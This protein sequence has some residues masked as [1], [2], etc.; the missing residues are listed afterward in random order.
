[1]PERKTYGSKPLNTWSQAAVAACDWFVNSQ[2]LQK[3]PNWDANHGRFL[4]NV[5]IPSLAA[6][7][8]IGWTQARA[9]MCLLAGYRR[10]GDTKYLD[11]ARR[12]LNYAKILQNLDA[13]NPLTFGAFHEETP[14]SPFSY[15]RDAIEVADAFLQWHA[16]TGDRDAIER[17]NLFFRW[18]K[19]NAWTRFPGF[20]PWVKGSVRF[21]DEKVAPRPFACEMGCAT[22]L[23][24]AYRAT[25]NNTYRTMSLAIADSTMKNYLPPGQ[26]PLRESARTRLSQHTD[27]DGTIYNDDG[28][29]VGL[30]NA[31]ALT[32]RQKYL[33]AAMQ[34]ADYFNVARNPCPVFSGIGSV[35]N[36]LLEVDHVTGRAEYRKTAERLARQ[37]LRLQVKTGSPLVKGAF[38]GE[39]EGGKWYVEGSKNDDFVTT[40]VTA[41]AA[42]VLFKLEGVVWPR[43]YS[44]EF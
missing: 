5:H 32:G 37:L 15:P 10:T 2:V 31:Y 43:G 38:R 36:F 30:L 24:H 33:N 7:W 21:D 35:A 23:A 3:R 27:A 20:G 26:G 40:R 34:I 6:T 16:T 19:R 13:R 29:G 39:D 22:I 42:L 44:T 18:F 1:M 11:C 4:Y 17:A 41:Y 25:R 12:G 14:H 28:G 8:G 9:V